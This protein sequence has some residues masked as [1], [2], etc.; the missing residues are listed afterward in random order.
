[1]KALCVKDIAKT[2]EKKSERKKQCFEKI[3]ELCYKRI[4]KCVGM[5]AYACFYLV[6]EFV[7]GYP[8]YNLNEA[9][10]YVLQQLQKNGFLVKYF[11][12]R[13]LHI[14]WETQEVKNKN[15]QENLMRLS[16]TPPD[17]HVPMTTMSYGS[18][19]SLQYDPLV[20]A[21]AQL[22]AKT[23]ER[24]SPI[25]NELRDLNVGA[26]R[27]IEDPKPAS[28]RASLPP[29]RGRGRGKTKAKPIA[30]FKPSGK[31]ILNL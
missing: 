17:V 25:P 18:T 22:V 10:A 23:D 9:V 15:L 13:S 5:N 2:F 3:M 26:Q 19:P 20:S 8:I 12:P 28:G 27:E 21:A 16:L 30:E 29:S 14:S 6:P 11:F 31:F 1:M 24:L 4:E 7:L